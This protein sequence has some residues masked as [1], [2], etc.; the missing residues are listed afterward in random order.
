MGMFILH[1]SYLVRKTWPGKWLQENTSNYLHVKCRIRSLCRPS[2]GHTLSVALHLHFQERQKVG[3]SSWEEASLSLPVHW[4]IHLTAAVW[5]NSFLSLGR[6]LVYQWP[7]GVDLVRFKSFTFFFTWIVPGVAGNFIVLVKVA[8]LSE[9]HISDRG[10]SLRDQFFKSLLLTTVVFPGNVS[11]ESS[12]NTQVVGVCCK[13]PHL[14]L[15]LGAGCA[16]PP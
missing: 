10:R 9:K 6:C 12:W 11:R 3:S 13:M 16:L 2:G 5:E 7:N 15:L 14:R 8:V 1:S 4:L